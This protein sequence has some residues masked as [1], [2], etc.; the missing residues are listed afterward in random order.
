[1]FDIEVFTHDA[2]PLRT[3]LNYMPVKVKPPA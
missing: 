1:V 2:L 3:G